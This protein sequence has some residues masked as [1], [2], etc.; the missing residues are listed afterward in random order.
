[1]DRNQAQELVNSVSHWHHRYEIFE[2]VTTPGTYHPREMFEHLQLPEDLSNVRALDIGSSSGFFSRELHLRG[3]RVSSID[4]KPKKLTGF[5]VMEEVVGHKF[6]FHR[7]NVRDIHEDRLGE[8]ELVLFLGVL[9]H[10]PDMIDILRRIRRVCKGS[11]FVETVYHPDKD[12]PDPSLANISYARYYVADTNAQDITNF[13]IP[14]RKCVF[15][16]LEDC[17]FKKEWYWENGDRLLVKATVVDQ[18]H[19]ESYKMKVAYGLSES[20]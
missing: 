16:M 8:F 3:A 10:L 15:D 12:M 11:L 2:G 17:G 7:M 13:W 20:A 5:G 1:M 18:E 4:Y 9:Y 19:R 14:N 6:D